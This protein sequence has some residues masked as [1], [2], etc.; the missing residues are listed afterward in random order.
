MAPIL[1][2][3][4]RAG[5]LEAPIPSRWQHD[6]VPPWR[7]L[8]AELVCEVRAGNVDLGRWLR[9]PATF[10]RWRPDRLPI[11]CGLEQ[12]SSG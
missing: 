4:D 12:L 2:L 5:P 11:E 6:A 1:A 10:L 3:I 8:P 9:Q 7:R